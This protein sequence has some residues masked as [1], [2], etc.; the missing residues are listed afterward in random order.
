LFV[1]ASTRWLR[2]Q[3]TDDVGFLGPRIAATSGKDV[4]GRTSKA[5]G[6]P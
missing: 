4:A 5:I 3:H 6:R 2:H 1:F